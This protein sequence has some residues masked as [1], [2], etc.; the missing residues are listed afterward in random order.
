MPSRGYER[1]RTQ[2]SSFI[3]FE[4]RRTHM[5]LAVLALLEAG[6]LEQPS[7]GLDIDRIR[8]YVAARLHLIP[9]YRQRLAFTPLQGHPIWVDDDRL[10]L[11]Y[12]V[13]QTSL[14]RPGS[15]TQL[16]ELAG[17]ILSQQLD[18]EKPLWELWFIEGL[19]DGR[20]AMLAK[21]HHCMVDGVAGVGLLNVLLSPS[22]EEEIGEAPHWQP[23]PAPG[24]VRLAADELLHRARAPLEAFGA[25]RRALAQPGRT[26][27][28][29]SENARAMGQAI[30]EGLQLPAATPLN[31]PIGTH[32]RVDWKTLDLAEVKAV[33]KRLDG[34]VNDVVLTIIAGALR[35]FLGQRRL[36]LRGLDYRVVIPV[37]LRTGEEMTISGN[38]VSGWLLSL[39]VDEARPLRRFQKIQ[40]ETRRLKRSAAAEGIDLFARIVDWTGSTWLTK[41]GVR[42]V[43]RL[44]PYNLIVSNVPGPQFPLYMMGAPVLEVHP[45]LPL[46]E[47]QGLAVAIL[48]YR[49]KLCCGL[50]ADWDLVPDLSELADAIPAAFAELR[51][52][53]EKRIG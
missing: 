45:Q 16:K 6:P 48:S 44:H 17:R 3:M 4:R 50:S 28:A 7:G 14:P 9:R 42:L 18:R 38:R 35:R 41:L 37:N 32:R 8:D 12:H 49:G 33:K 11:R 46:F 26:W 23:Q 31:Q 34:T 21:A 43:S 40:A 39:P 22:A 29:L 19:A 53:A 52:A 27:Q 25:V 10:N 30:A 47:N 1:L 24:L 51:E 20:C 5:H 15:M 36:R 2:D 13:R